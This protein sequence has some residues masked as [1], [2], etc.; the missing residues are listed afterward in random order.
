MGKSLTKEIFVDR[1]NKKHNNFYDYSRVNYINNS[2]KVEIGC[3]IHGWF[4]QT[5]GAHIQGN[6]CS[7]CARE[8]INKSWKQSYEELVRRFN[9]KHNNKYTYPLFDYTNYRDKI[10]IICG[11]HGVFEQR[12]GDHMAGKGCRK[13]HSK[14]ISLNFEE[15]VKRANEIHNFEYEYL[16]DG[17]VNTASNIKIKCKKHGIFEQSVHIHIY[18][19]SKCPKC[20]RSK[21]R[22][23]IENVLKEL[24]EKHNNKYEYPDFEYTGRHQKIKI[25]CPIHGEFEKNLARHKHGQ[26]CSKCSNI[27]MSLTQEEAL[28]KFEEVHNYR[29]DYSEVE[30]VN[31]LT[32]VKIK[33][34]IH[35]EFWQTPQHHISGSGCQSCAKNRVSETEKELF[36]YIKTLYE[37][38][39]LNNYNIISP[40]ELDIFI[41]SLNKAIEFNGKFWH[42]SSEH[43]KP[44]KHALKSNLCRQKGIKLLHLR[45][46]LWLNKKE[47]M[48]EVIIK[49]LER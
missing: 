1:S 16:E 29:Y 45:E 7:E 41:P 35:G 14:S 37:D 49:F 10:K 44:G 21:L 25:I 38:S 48:K 43:F 40:K 11:E 12:I 9:E 3:P 17:Y 27:Q 19:E 5:P 20:Q 26:G 46:D 36:E 4:F 2:T 15:V 23:N 42:Y 39:T 8:K 24:N 31:Y 47:H 34:L 33:C 18:Q 6:G 32:K 13:C 28:T 22:N 30:Y